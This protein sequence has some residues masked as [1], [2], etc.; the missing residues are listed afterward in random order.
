VV[1]DSRVWK[2]GALSFSSRTTTATA[3]LPWVQTLLAVPPR[4]TKRLK[5]GVVSKSTGRASVTAP[6]VALIARNPPSFPETMR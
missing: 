5:A 6:V 2:K 4:V 3:M 1:R